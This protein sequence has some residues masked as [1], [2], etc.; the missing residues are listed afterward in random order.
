MRPGSLAKPRG[1]SV[2]HC[3]VMARRLDAAARVGK[4]PTYV[5]AEFDRSGMR[6][7]QVE[8]IYHP[9]GDQVVETVN[10]ARR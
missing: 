2:K 5:D 3:L 10:R 9:L 8:E 6:A 7:W 4:H 1:W